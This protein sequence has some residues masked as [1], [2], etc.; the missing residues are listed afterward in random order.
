MN[1]DAQWIKSYKIDIIYTTATANMFFFWKIYLL[2]LADSEVQ[3]VLLPTCELPKLKTIDGSALNFMVKELT[4]APHITK[5]CSCWVSADE[6][7]TDEGEQRNTTII[8]MNAFHH[9]AD[10]RVC[11]ETILEYGLLYT[12]DTVLKP[13]LIAN[14][15][16]EI[17]RIIERL[18]ASAQGSK[19]IQTD[20][21]NFSISVKAARLDTWK[22]K[23]A[24]D[25]NEEYALTYIRHK[26]KCHLVGN[27]TFL[28]WW[29]KTFLGETEPNK[30]SRSDIEYVAEAW[31]ECDHHHLTLDDPRHESWVKAITAGC[32]AQTY[33]PS[34]CPT[35]EDDDRSGEEESN[36]DEGGHDESNRDDDGTEESNRDEG[37]QNINEQTVDSQQKRASTSTSPLS[38]KPRN[39]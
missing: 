37:S 15:S 16:E 8:L 36:R 30:Y 20:I 21:E 17:R 35:Q 27:N 26:I 33:N 23:F 18:P 29:P 28:N 19:Q 2:A 34:A 7:D 1:V 12:I 6:R 22:K 11:I 3:A 10:K 39:E 4:K 25:G 24:E 14:N 5:F 31:A 9:H 32:S 38:K 13:F